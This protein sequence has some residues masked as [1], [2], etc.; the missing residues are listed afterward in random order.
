MTVVLDGKKL[1]KE[2]EE[3]LKQRANMLKK[4][5][6]LSIIYVGDDYASGVYVN[7]KKKACERIGLD[8]E[9][10]R[11]DS[12]STTQQVQNQIKKLNKAENVCGIM[13]QHPMPKQI[14]EDACFNM[15]EE[16]K[17]VDGLGKSSLGNISVLKDGF[18][19][20]T[21]KGVISLLKN[22][23]IE[24]SGKHAVVIGRSRIVGKP[25]AYLLTNENATVTLAHSKTENLKKICKSADIIV[26]AVGSP[27][28]ITKDKIKKGVVIIDTG[29]NEG[30]VGDFDLE[31][32]K[33][34]SSAYTPV[35]GGV[36]P[37][38]IISLIE[39]CI[40]SAEKHDA[41]KN[42]I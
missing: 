40:I 34:K 30:N 16:E 35:P 13:I 14:D 41:K 3:N 11:M 5:Y 36:G 23:K 10:V 29:F 38:T 24:L 18:V 7:M 12:K 8:C 32:C 20:A 17:D 25:I 21:A 31:A 28:F 1:S 19:P 33:K 15:I 42:Q 26:S 6:M 9:I 4:K 22:Y 39:Q 37:M 27:K 2:I